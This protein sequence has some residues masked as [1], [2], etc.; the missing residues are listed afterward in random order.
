MK[1]SKNH[2]MFVKPNARNNQSFNLAKKSK[3][4]YLYV[5]KEMMKPENYEAYKLK[6]AA[7]KTWKD[8]RPINIYLDAPR[9]FILKEITK[10][11]SLVVYYEGTWRPLANLIPLN[12]TKQS[13][14]K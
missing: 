3:E 8:Y 13:S 6:N 12:K 4:L 14:K 7:V 10:Q 9:T 2:K 11:K 5:F 1:L